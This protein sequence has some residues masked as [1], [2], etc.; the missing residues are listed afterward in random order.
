MAHYKN[1]YTKNE[2]MMLWQLH[3][4][5]HQLAEQHQSAHQINMNAESVIQQYH[6]GNLKVVRM[7]DHSV[8]KE[9]SAGANAKE[10]MNTE[11]KLPVSLQTA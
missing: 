9:H 11:K 6:L 2:D 3:E 5:R 7:T 8:P 10:I 4:I 1:D